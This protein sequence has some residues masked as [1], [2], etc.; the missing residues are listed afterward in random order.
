MCSAG[1]EAP[2]VD[3]DRGETS[4]DRRGVTIAATTRIAAESIL[5]AVP[6]TVIRL[7]SK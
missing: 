6:V 4:V 2:T 3:A 7:L 5:E 1:R